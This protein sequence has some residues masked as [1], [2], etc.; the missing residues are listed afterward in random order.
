LVSTWG[1]TMDFDFVDWDDPDHPTG[2]VE[3]VA[4]HGI[5]QAEVESVLEGDGPEDARRTAPY[6]HTKEGW[7]TMGKYLVVVYESEE[8]AGYIVVR[9]VTAYDVTPP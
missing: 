9:P 3:H 7:T 8:S 6:R 5:T 2:N 1:A 4:E